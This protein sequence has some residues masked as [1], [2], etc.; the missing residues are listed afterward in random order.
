MKLGL[1][2][3]IA[4]LVLVASVIG[5]HYKGIADSKD[6]TDKQVQKVEDEIKEEQKDIKKNVDEMKVDVAVI[7]QILLKKYGDPDKNKK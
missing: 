4:V 3:L 2:T 5:A 1:S 6:Y 7:K